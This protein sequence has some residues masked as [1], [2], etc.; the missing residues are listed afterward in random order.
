M[1]LP[2]AASAQPVK[3]RISVL[4]DSSGSMLLTPDIVT[5]PE[6]C[7]AQGWNGCT[8]SGN[9]TAAQETCNACVADT[10][11]FRATCASSWTATCRS[12]YQTCY[13][14]LTGQTG[15][16]QSLNIVEGVSTRGD[17]SLET[18]GCDLNGD[19]LPNDS[20]MYQAKTALSNVIAT[21][22]E[23]E[24]A[25]WRYAQTDGGQACA[26]N[27]TC[28]KT[29][30]G[31]TIMS[32]DSIGGTTRC[33]L[34]ATMLDSTGAT[35]AGQCDPY[36]WNGASNTWD[37]SLCDFNNTFERAVCEAYALNRVRTGGI[38]PLDG[39]STVN[40]ALP[41]SDHKFIK[42]AGAFI[43]NNACDPNGGQRLVDFPATG[44]DDNYD[45]MMQWIDGTQTN[46]ATDVEIKPQGGTPIAASLRD[47][48]T[49]ILANLAADAKTP[50]RKYQV[51][52]L[53]DGGE[54]CETVAAAKTAA[55][56]FQNL[57]FTNSAGVNVT[58]YNVPVYVIGFAIC[59]GGATNC[60]TALDLNGIASSGGTSS[61][62]LVKNQLELQ[63][64]LA[65]IVASSVVTEKC[66]G[67]DDNCNGLVDEDFP[68][69]NSACSAGVGECLR[70]GQLVCTADQLGLACNATAGTPAAE[71]CNGKDDNCNGLVDDGINCQGCVAICSN[72]AHCDTCNNIDEDCDGKIDED[73][74]PVA[75]GPAT[76]ECDPGTTTCVN[77]VTGC[78]GGVGPATEVCDNKDNDC[79]TIVD[80][81]T[82][83]CYPPA[84]AGCNTTTGVCLGICKFGTSTCTAG[85]NGT[86]SGAI[87]PVT[88]IACNGLDDNCNG[89]VD[90]GSGTEQCNGKDDDCDGKIDEGVATTDPDIGAACGTP[91]FV[92]ECK[93][94][95]VQCV[96]GA[97]TCVGEVNPTT[98][99]CDNKDNNCDGVVDNN[100]P[101]FGGACGTSVGECD[102]GTLQCV[103]GAPDCVGDTGP[104][105]EV[106]DNKDNN[107]NGLTDEADPQLGDTCNTLPNG[108]VVATEDGEC[109]FGV[110]A[111]TA[112]GLTCVGTV[113]PI[114]EKCNVLDDDCD[115]KIDEDFPQLGM[116]CDNGRPGV[117][118]QTGV[119][120]CA[121]N[122]LGVTCTAPQGVAGTETC[123][124]LDDD[125][126]GQTDELPLPVVGTVCAPAAGNCQPGLW[127]CTNGALVCGNPGSGTTE[128]CN[129]VDD[130][131]DQLIDESPLPGEGNQCTDPGFEQIGDTGECEFGATACVS[132]S[133]GCVG[134]K[135]PT[136]EICDGKDNDCDGIV[137]DS[138]ACPT[139]NVCQGGECVAPCGS[140]EFP[141]SAGYLCENLPTA[142]PPG[143]YCVHNPC[144]GVT[145]GANEVCDEAT[146]QCKNLCDGVTCPSGTECRQGF[147]LDCFHLP[148]LCTP[149]QLCIAEPGG[150]GQC[151][152][153][154]CDPN[155]CQ[156]GETCTNG[157]CSDACGGGCADGT[158]CVGGQCVNDACAGA[159][160]TAGQVC[161]P[162]NGSCVNPMCEGI[163]CRTGEVCVPTTGACEPDPCITTE[164]PTGQTCSIDG[165][166]R[167]VCKVPT[168]PTHE[169]VTAAGGG[170]NAG[171]SGA[172]PWLFLLG[173][174]PLFRRR[175][176]AA[177]GRS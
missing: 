46:F 45:T 97:E 152:D 44:Y 74:A 54:S 43:N 7:V 158:V 109:R 122:G 131:C 114:A 3:N 36:T 103:G 125:C 149:G 159:N 147:C 61:A 148:E 153:N 102:P 31:L 107:C 71:I 17:G 129:G 160:C 92:G 81:M 83:P 118:H 51:I 98:E 60:Q 75:C 172:A 90:E 78:S 108:T 171:D 2:I 161:D 127:A 117:C 62:F 91:P 132:G 163:S 126:D 150:L 15:C 5:M 4:V 95:V 137:D 65:Q 136:A 128:V 18:P 24:F 156:A 106:C 169:R 177:G 27:A 68:G 87:T 14:S 52:I 135:G 12:D 167:A 141:C 88:E 48:K 29:P 110:L 53:T 76:G 168:G 49:T 20:R 174:A 111:C 86:C 42:S 28:P 105:T 84:T 21:F 145:C 9:P 70:T 67:L 99:A 175:R 151:Q 164:C 124:G 123:N 157:V 94:G 13:Q 22:G 176:R 146:G 121:A 72:A 66:N 34:N 32:C 77:G 69:K 101:G 138:A 133:I 26:T 63:A 154:L 143:S 38:S 37:C 115:T 104:F 155:P 119:Y 35:T 173:F 142:D 19:G 8:S 134:Y 165:D 170:C 116:A 30:G 1:L 130:D 85:V 144:E 59:P 140:G 33:N 120:V 41:S 39:T 11:H 89:V 50:C 73:F 6:T 166:G 55:A 57:S 64:A 23:V 113:G 82:S 25:L 16:A 100:V 47:M 10:I 79:D 139:G 162:S 40:C 93:A 58:G 56:S 112:G 80:G 96:G